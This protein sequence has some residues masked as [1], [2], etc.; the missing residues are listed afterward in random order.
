[1]LPSA[2]HLAPWDTVGTPTGG[3]FAHT[4]KSLGI[5]QVFTLAVRAVDSGGVGPVATVKCAT[6]PQ[7]M[8]TLNCASNAL[9]VAEYA[10]P[11][12]GTGITSINYTVQMSKV[13]DAQAG[14]RRAR[15]NV[16]VG[17]ADKDTLEA[18]YH[19]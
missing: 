8:L 16:E 10:N 18:D 7:N 12:A 2:P 3:V 1:M 6:A 5:G 4:F 9:L 11:Y 14:V 17:P 15:R 19:Y 13:G